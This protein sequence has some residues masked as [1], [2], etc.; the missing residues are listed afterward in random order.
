MIT[1]AKTHS[2]GKDA[3]W[4]GYTDSRNTPD[5]MGSLHRPEKDPF[6]VVASPALEVASPAQRDNRIAIEQIDDSVV[7]DFSLEKFNLIKFTVKKKIGLFFEDTFP[8]IIQSIFAPVFFVIYHLCFVLKIKGKTNLD[9]TTGPMLFVSNHIGFY[10]SF[11]FDLFVKPFSHI[12]PFRFM[13]SRRFIT[14]FLALLKCIGV[15]DLVYFLFGVFRITPG[16]GA[17][18]SL[19]KAYEIIKNKGTVVMYPE[20]RI[21]HPTNVHPEAIGPFKWGAAILAKNTGVQVVPVSFR[22]TIR[23]D[24]RGFMKVR[25]GIDVCIGKPFF[26]DQNKAP[27]AIADDMR[28][29]V[30]E[31]FEKVV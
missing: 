24:S 30:V 20:G 23:T 1:Q 22:K 28:D 27:E 15:I 21:W 12:L 16:E 29:K 4:D 8:F 25:R 11:I 19:K 13:G 7:I 26:V 9:N 14:H 31:L 5:S 18:K 17:E 10:D 2:R 3:V 6:L